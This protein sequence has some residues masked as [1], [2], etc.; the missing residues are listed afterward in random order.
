MRIG[1]VGYGV[2]G[3]ALCRFFGRTPANTLLIYDKYAD[4]F[5]TSHAKEAVNTADLV[6]IAV[7]TPN[8]PSTGSTDL[9]AVEEAVSWITAPMCV[10]STVPPGTTRRLIHQTTKPI[11]FS[12]EY[13]GEAPAHPWSEEDACGFVIVGAEPA[14]AE[15]IV[16]A[17]H[18]AAGRGLRFA[19]TD[20]TTAE[21][22]KYM[23]NCY[24]ATKVAFVNQFYEIARE[25]KVDFSKLRELWLMDTR[26]GESHTRVTA[27][28]GFGGR[29][30]PKDLEAIAA[31]MRPC[32]GA[33]LLEAVLA[34]N[35]LVRS[36][37]LAEVQPDL[38]T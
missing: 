13:I 5:N 24:L 19:V 25:M 7:P 11:A 36:K 31:L 34:F 17:Y 32:G 37:A 15:R 6:F 3:H 27:Q 22:C 38:R 8:V 9:L 1:I 29:C 20:P 23:E 35:Q 33:P 14:L 4:Q 26:I 10:R 28:R 21:L 2:V 12:P 30:L 18:S 16:A